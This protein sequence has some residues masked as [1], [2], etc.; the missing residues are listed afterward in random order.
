LIAKI[1]ANRTAAMVFVELTVKS[2]NPHKERRRHQKK[3]AKFLSLRARQ[4]KKT[5]SPAQAEKLH[6][7]SIVQFN[8]TLQIV[9]ARFLLNG[10]IFFKKTGRKN[11]SHKKDFSRVRLFDK[12]FDHR[13]NVA[14][15]RR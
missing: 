4:K 1:F 8:Q 7:T 10:A 6:S 5:C 13:A 3:K 14:I 15:P 12:L 2:K 11:V 9:P